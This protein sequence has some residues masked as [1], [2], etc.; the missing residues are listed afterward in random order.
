VLPWQQI[1]AKNQELLWYKYEAHPQFALIPQ[2]LLVK[3]LDPPCGFFSSSPSPKIYLRP[4]FTLFPIFTGYFHTHEFGRASRASA[5]SKPPLSSPTTSASGSAEYIGL[6]V[7][8][9]EDGFGIST[10]FMH[11][12]SA[13]LFTHSTP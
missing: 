8:D 12:F 10:D 13:S 6:Q 2:I 11:S 3:G 4:F 9:K 5:W 7:T 1:T